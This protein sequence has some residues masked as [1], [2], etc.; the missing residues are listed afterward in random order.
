MNR[1]IPE[2]ASLRRD[3]LIEIGYVE[4]NHQRRAFETIADMTYEYAVQVRN[5]DNDEWHQVTQW[6][7]ESNPYRQGIKPEHN[8]RIVRRLVSK[9]EEVMEP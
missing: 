6:G 7:A 8:E 4:G 3:N 9:P 1:M 5:D 2:E